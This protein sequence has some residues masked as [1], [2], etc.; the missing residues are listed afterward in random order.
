MMYMKRGTGDPAF[1]NQSRDRIGEIGTDPVKCVP[2]S[3]TD[4]CSEAAHP[5]R[6]GDANLFVVVDGSCQFLLHYSLYQGSGGYQGC[7]NG[8][9]GHSHLVARRKA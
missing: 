8:I 3:S 1:S 6:A 7:W 9:D 5:L 4:V 2:A